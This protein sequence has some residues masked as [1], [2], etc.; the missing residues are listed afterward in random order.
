MT[1][2]KLQA[3]VKTFEEKRALLDAQK[4]AFI[5]SEGDGAISEREQV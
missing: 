2:F 4:N 1:K 3:L 5:R